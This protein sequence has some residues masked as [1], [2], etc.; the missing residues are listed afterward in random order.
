MSNKS[1]KTNNAASSMLYGSSI[2]AE[3]MKV[4][5]ESIGVGSLSDDAAKELAE[6]VSL[7]LKRIVQDAAKFMHHAKRQKMSVR[8]IDQSLKIRNIEPQYGFVSKD[9]VPFRF[10]SGGGRELH[11]TEDKELDLS[12]ITANS[13][14]KI[15]LDLTLRS[16][17]FVVE[18]IQPTVPENPPP[19]SKDSQ[20][21]DS[22]NP[23]IKLDQGLNKDA[24]G[25]PTTGKIHKLKNVETIHVK[26]LAT[27]EL[28]VEQQL[29]YKEITE[30][31]VGSDEPRRAEALQSLGSDPG[32]HEMLPRMCTFIAEGVK[33]NVVQNNLAL[34]IY[35]MRMVRALLDNP[36]LFLEK[37]LHELIPSV[38]T[39]IVSKQLCMRP[40][41]DNH[42]ALRDFAS[43][44]MAQICKT[45][46]TLTNNLQTRV[47]RIFSKALQNDMTHLSSLYGSIEGLAELGGEVVK[48][49]IIPRLKFISERIEPHLLGT[50]MSN[51]DK[52]AAGHIRAMLQKCCP[53]ILKQMRSAPDIGEEYKNDYG[54]LGPSLCQAV[55]KA[56]N[57]PANST[58][59]LASTTINT[60]PITSAAQT[61]TTIGRVSM[62]NTTQRQSPVVATMPQIRAIQANQPPQKF[63]IVTQNSPQQSQPKVVRRGSSP[64]SVV[65]SSSSANG[66]NASNSN[67]SSTGSVSGSANS[68]LTSRS[69]DNSIVDVNSLIIETEIVRAPPELDDLSHLE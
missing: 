19:L 48:V 24:A 36:S 58:V 53:P 52:T 66:A 20:F 1:S 45:F 10:A 15:P 11:F 4:I 21:V 50:S 38:M 35:L 57:A 9:F 18:G 59:A 65:L 27:H 55:V 30:A 22:V 34:L 67:S 69:N 49:F 68:L 33:V 8:D 5:A 63:V 26:Q 62:P 60:A 41:L 12:E 46:N 54:F 47:T 51:T 7:K 61:A 31:C 29:Y 56:R 13:S 16:H 64:H 37:Y 42:W 25:K 17:W 40:E 3:S 14:I 39:C 32:L 2:S 28:S 23:V 43:R 6:D 44:L